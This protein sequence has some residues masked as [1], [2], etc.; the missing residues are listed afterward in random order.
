MPGAES[1][2]G[3]QRC[4]HRKTG[5]EGSWDDFH[6]PEPTEVCMLLV[7]T[8][9]GFFSFLPISLA[10]LGHQHLSKMRLSLPQPFLMPFQ[11][12][13]MVCTAA[14]QAAPARLH[15]SLLWAITC[16]RKECDAGQGQ[17]QALLTAP[18]SSEHRG[19]RSGFLSG[20]SSA[21]REEIF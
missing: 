10:V 9:Q 21:G 1:S 7:N 13:A 16:W 5:A 17:L 6:A 20:M 12:E 19:A 18:N 15:L 8:L 14:L 3:G 2:S 4:E 11:R